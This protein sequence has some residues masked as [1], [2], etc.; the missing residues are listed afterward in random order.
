VIPANPIRFAC[1]DCQVVFDMCVAPTSE[2]AEEI[3][4]ADFEGGIDVGEPSVCPFCGA[5]E[6]K[7]THDRATQYTP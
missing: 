1:G 4:E 5:A 7:P 2:W 6:L 3:D